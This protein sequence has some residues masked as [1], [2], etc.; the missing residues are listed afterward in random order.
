MK[1][2]SFIIKV[3][4]LKRRGHNPPPTKAHKDQ[5]NDYNRR[6]FKKNSEE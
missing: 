1:A 3:K 2:K 6:D 5:R 4:N